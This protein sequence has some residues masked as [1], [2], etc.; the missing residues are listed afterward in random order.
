MH[1][2][3]FFIWVLIFVKKN[4]F[5][6]CTLIFCL[7]TVAYLLPNYYDPWRTVYHDFI[8]YGVF[9]CL[10]V[11]TLLENNEILINKRIIF[12]FCVALIPLMQNLFGKIY[13][14]GDALIASIYIFSFGLAIT[15]GLNLR[16]N[17][18]LDQILIFVSAVCIFVG[19]VS[20]FI[21]LK[22]WL[23]LT[24]GGVWTVDMPPG[25]RPFAN[26][27][28]P[29]N[30]ASFLLLSCL[31]SLYLFEKKI[32][33]YCSGISLVFLLLFCLALTQSRT[34]WAFIL[35]FTIW[36][37]W[38]SPL[39]STRSTR[40]SIGYCLAFFI[41]AVLSIP[42]LSAVFG[43]ISTS[44]IVTRATTGYLRIPMW[45]QM[46][47][48]ISNEPIWGYG[49]N[50]VSVAQ[51]SVYLE[52][53]TREWTEHSHNILLDLM[54]WNGIPMGVL[55]IGFLSYWLWQ[56]SK[57]TNCLEVFISL[58]M[59]GVLIVHGMLEYPL[60]YAFFLLPAGL[61]L[62]LI[63]F[64]LT[65]LKVINVSKSLGITIF[66]GGLSLFIWIFIEY[67]SVEKDFRLLQFELKNIGSL[68]A[69]NEAPDIILLTQLRERIRF[70]RTEP[71]KNMDQEQ[72]DWMKQV[73]YRYGTGINL[74]RYS[75]ALLLNGQTKS[76]KKYLKILNELHRANQNID[77]LFNSNDSLSYRWKQTQVTKQ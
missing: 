3:P 8:I 27:A 54:I 35:C 12:I 37:S 38:K 62:G 65:S 31:A 47:L 16:R 77:S 70:L 51:I 63:S 42:Y 21:I 64:D 41:L 9:L 59:I 34:V 33:N 2:H 1:R 61:I 74:Y 44:D 49:W 66:I 30:C 55:I 56:L 67:R 69:K 13:F 60:E 73:T 45:K 10:W 18:K 76:A 53:P 46:L 72:L 6:W 11:K 17:Y 14:F 29:N 50:Q 7:A 22:Q 40:Y 32:L 58:S 68:H 5:Y 28:Q 20:A 52:Y 36:W 57:I 25:G 39:F 4:N 71:L 19:L 15:V 23:I 26:F 24:N 75:Q 48:A 43:M